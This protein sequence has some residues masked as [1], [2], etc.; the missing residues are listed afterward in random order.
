MEH[1]QSKKNRSLVLKLLWL[2]VCSIG[3]FP[4]GTLAGETIVVDRIVAVVNDEII[5]LFDL[6]LAFQPFAENIRALGYSPEKER[7]T[8]FKLRSDLLSQ[9][10][11]QK[12]TGQE[13]K[14][15]NI[16][17]SEQEIDRAIE[18]IKESRFYTDE[19][20]RAGLAK[21]GLTMEE[22]R[23][24]LKEQ[25]LRNKLV[26][27]EVK[28]KI[29]ITEVDIK[30][31]YESHVEN[32][33]GE[34]KYHLWNIFIRISALADGPEK[35]NALEKMEAVL[36]R[37]KQGQ[38]FESFAVTNPGSPST[39]AGA[40]LGLYRLDELSSQLQDVVKNMRT[41]EFSSILETDNGYQIIYVQ[42][43]LETESKSFSEVKPEIRDI[44]YNQAVDDKYQAW[45]NELR[46]KSHIKIIQ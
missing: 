34:K 32:Y 15:N 43:I 38:P 39:P 6:N 42:K 25:L 2:T 9:L 8:L 37:L 12:L 24:V 30:N 11:N 31:Y 35:Q 13:T 22:Y 3:I 23:K 26:N 4:I 21:Q 28:S 10:I 14:R 7:E 20:L 17:I 41:G 1:F 18:R 27:R 5:T 33:R 16:T 19:D 40:D 29:V 45:L 46:K 44:L 36:V